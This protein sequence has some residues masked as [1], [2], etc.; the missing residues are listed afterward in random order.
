[1]TEGIIKLY[2]G[3]P[4][5]PSHQPLITTIVVCKTRTDYDLFCKACGVSPRNRKMIC[6][7]ESDYRVSDKLR[8]ISKCEVV[9]LGYD[10]RSSSMPYSLSILVRVEMLRQSDLINKAYVFRDWAPAYIE[11]QIME[12]EAREW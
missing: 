11:P 8:G 4:L 5:N 2:Q 1:M 3:I 12:S 10:P 6:A 7:S 9:F